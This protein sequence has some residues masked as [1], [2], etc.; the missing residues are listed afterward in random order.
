MTSAF[1][2]FVNLSSCLPGLVR[3]R[4]VLYRETASLMYHPWAQLLAWVT[5]EMPWIAV[6][7]LVGPTIAY[8]LIGFGGG[9]SGCEPLPTSAFR[10]RHLLYHHVSQGIFE[11]ATSY[12]A[13][14]TLV[15]AC[16]LLGSTI[17]N[18][19]PSLELAQVLSA[20]CANLGY[21]GHL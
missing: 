10:S 8:F 19:L 2:A 21:S 20:G 13:L 9:V 18:A 1:A 12:L 16:V 3:S 7:L 5:A 6:I 11:F 15:L 14:Y 17:A 4:P